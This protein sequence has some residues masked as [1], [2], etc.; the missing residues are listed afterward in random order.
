MPI[1]RDVTAT[2]TGRVISSSKQST[3]GASSVVHRFDTL[4]CQPARILSASAGPAAPISRL[5]ADA[6]ETR[7]PVV[8][9]ADRAVYSAG[10]LGI[11]VLEHFRRIRLHLHRGVQDCTGMYGVYLILASCHFV[12]RSHEI[13]LT[14]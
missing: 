11:L 13:L 3:D 9:V 2:E 14:L 12:V 1:S 7:P 8:G 10:H 6:M 5:R 4:D